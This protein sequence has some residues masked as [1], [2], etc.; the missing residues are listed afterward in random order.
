MTNQITFVGRLKK[1]ITQD[2]YYI[3]KLEVPRYF[4]REN[5]F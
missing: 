4:K 2:D 5:G 1:M 3:I